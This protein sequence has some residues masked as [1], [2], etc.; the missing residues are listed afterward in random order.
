MSVMARLKAAGVE[1]YSRAEWGSVR[2]AAYAKRRTTHPMPEGPAP[3]HFLH[4]TVTPDTDTVLEGK[5]G[6][7]KVESYGLSTPP[8]VS[9]HGLVTNEGKWFEGQNYGVKGTHTINDKNVPGFPHDLNRYGY[10]LAI[11]QNIHDAVTETQVQVLAMGFAAT[12]LDG[13][14]VR[15]APIYPHN[16]FANK[17]CPGDKATALL[18]RIRILKDH[19]VRNGLPGNTST[20][21]KDWFDMATKEELKLVVDEVIGQKFKDLYNLAANGTAAKNH[22]AVMAAIAGVAEDAAVEVMKT[23]IVD[24]QGAFDPATGQPRPTIAFSSHVAHM[25]TRVA[26]VLEDDTDGTVTP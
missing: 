24:M 16:K 22:Q 8:M 1:V 3:F 18:G 6:A 23:Q 9:Y 2:P 5:A 20:T 7:R 11:M 15:G 14:V 17:L 10:A 25:P 13:W 26:K 12:E 4:I 21:P 19:Y